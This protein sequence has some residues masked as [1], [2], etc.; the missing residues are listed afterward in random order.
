[1]CLALDTMPSLLFIHHTYC[2]PRYSIH[3]YIDHRPVDCR[4]QVV[5]KVV[6]QGS[7]Q[8]YKQGSE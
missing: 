8:G 1:M 5:S 4:L 6:K 7:K 3:R 2:L